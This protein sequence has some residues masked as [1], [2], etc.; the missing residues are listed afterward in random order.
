MTEAKDPDSVPELKEQVQ[1]TGA[2]AQAD[3]IN[4]NDDRR[5][6]PEIVT[7]IVQRERAKAYEK[8]KREALMDMQQQ[9]AQEAQATS[10]VPAAQPSLPN[11]PQQ[12]GGMNQLS[13]DQIRQMIAQEA[14][15]AL[16]EHVKSVQQQALVNSFVSKMQAAETKYPGMEQKLNELDFSTIA[17][18]IQHI[19]KM[20]NTADIMH[21]LIENPMKMGNLVSLFYSQPKLAEK[22]IKNLSSSI[23]MND[24]A[25]QAE[26]S[27]NEPFSQEKPSLNAGKDDGNMSV[28]DFKAMFKKQRLKAY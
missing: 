5:F 21:E 16:Q 7:K 28:S 23:R 11:Q 10:A 13:P 26:K 27:V 3:E 18:L 8:G 2:G 15:K 1:D 24:D 12:I 25:K 20:E 19:D 22:A 9:P 14:P 4:D 6:T 17:P